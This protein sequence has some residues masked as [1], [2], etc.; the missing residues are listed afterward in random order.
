MEILVF[1]TNLSNSKR[2]G[3]V[4]IYLNNHP[5]IHQWNVDLH[6]CDN[7]LR[8]VNLDIDPAEVEEIVKNAGYSCKELL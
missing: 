1:K 3:D 5:G 7:I 6:D 8:I 4:G 2:I